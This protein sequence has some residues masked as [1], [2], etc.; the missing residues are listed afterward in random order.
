MPARPS[1]GR[2]R[3]RLRRRARRAAAARLPGATRRAPGL[4]TLALQQLLAAHGLG[5]A[6]I[7][8][9]GSLTAQ[10]RMAEA[11]LGLAILPQSSLQDELR[12]GT[13]HP[14][15]APALTTTI[16]ITLIRRRTAFQTGAAQALAAA[17]TGWPHKPGTRT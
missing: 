11:G 9:V 1:P 2:R 17:L 8:P 5:T 12:T 3:D 13:L 10:K 4:Y 6:E 16:P 14:I 15:D 7:L